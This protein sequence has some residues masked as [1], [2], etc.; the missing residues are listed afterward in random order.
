MNEKI[1]ILKFSVI[2]GI[3]LGVIQ[4]FLAVIVYVMGVDASEA[5]WQAY[6]SGIVSTIAM[7]FIFVINQKKYRDEIN[8]GLLSLGEAVKIGVTIAVIAAVIYGIY[9]Y[10][11]M[12]VIEPD[13]AQNILDN[14]EQ[15][16][17]EQNPDM[18]DEQLDMALGMASKFSSP[19]ITVPLGIIGSAII[20][21][22][23]SIITGLF[24]KKSDSPL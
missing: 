24:V 17:L 22:V 19:A 12:T 4:I 20:G 10:L 2:P 14:A 15:A 5:G 16:M 18:S 7:I 8:D 6:V 13:F 3:T 1:S 23:I 21:L 9:N 11:F